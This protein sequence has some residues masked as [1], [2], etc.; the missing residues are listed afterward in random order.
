MIT[1]AT[2]QLRGV[3]VTDNSIFSSFP[4]FEIEKNIEG[5]EHSPSSKSKYGFGDSL[6]FLDYRGSVE[7]DAAANEAQGQFRT[8]D[9]VGSNYNLNLY[10]KR[11]KSTL[12]IWVTEIK[13]FGRY[14]CRMQTKHGVAE[15]FIRL[16]NRGI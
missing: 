10:G 1:E 3:P 2:I 15:G 7:K 13:H 16:R 5:K 8:I 6:Y 12:H 11:L 4:H 14:S 9:L